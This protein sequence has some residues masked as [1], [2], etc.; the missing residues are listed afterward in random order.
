MRSLKRSIV[1]VV[2]LCCINCANVT[3]Q[4]LI[5]FS[6]TETAWQLGHL[7]DVGQTVAIAKNP[8]CYYEAFYETQLLIGRHPRESDVY[9]WGISSALF[10]FWSRKFMHKHLPEN[11][12][13]AIR[14]YEVGFKAMTLY[15]NH[16]LGLRLDGSS[17]ARPLYS[18]VTGEKLPSPNS[19]RTLGECNRLRPLIRSGV[20]WKF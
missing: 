16:Q 3:R 10:H 12:S 7:I 4:D 11:W 13:I 18:G 2:A 20:T 17:K 19:G 9:L 8:D 14:S 15:N 6:S 5:R 1:L